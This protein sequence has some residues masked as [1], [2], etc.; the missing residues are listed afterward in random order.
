MGSL[1]SSKDI[2][3]KIYK[4]NVCIING[5]GLSVASG[6]ETFEELS[7]Q[8]WKGIPIYQIVEFPSLLHNPIQVAAFLREKQRIVR[9]A[10]PNPAHKALAEI[11]N[12]NPNV[13]VITHNVDGLEARAG[14]FNLVELYGSLLRNRIVKIKGH[15]INM[16]DII[17][18]GQETSRQNVSL[19]VRAITDS[20]SI[21]VI[22]STL[23]IDEVRVWVDAALKR[24][25]FSVEINPRPQGV[26]EY[27]IAEKAEDCLPEITHLAE[28]F[29]RK[30]ARRKI[31]RVMA[32]IRNERRPQSS[33]GRQETDNITSMGDFPCFF[34][35][36]GSKR[37]IIGL[38]SSGC[39]HAKEN[40]ACTHCGIYASDIWD[41]Q[42]G[43]L[44]EKK[45]A[46]ELKKYDYRKNPVITILQYGSFL[47]SSE[48]QDKTRLKMLRRL[49]R[50]ATL[51]RV[52]IESRPEFITK[53]SI[54]E[55]T[56]ILGDKEI[57]VG[58]A[59]DSKN[60]LIRN[61]ILCKNIKISEYE[62]AIKI[63]KKRDVR[64]LTYILV[65]PPFLSEAEAFREAKE[66]AEYAINQGSYAISLE[67]V[68][69]HSFTLQE[70]LKRYF[71]FR[72]PW[73]WT[74][75]RLVEQL[76]DKRCSNGSPVE[77]RIGGEIHSPP[78]L[79]AAFNCDNCSA[80]LSN[81]FRKHNKAQRRGIF[82]PKSYGKNT[83][84][85]KAL[86]CSCKNSWL[87]I[88]SEE[89]PPLLQH[90][91]NSYNI[92]HTSIETRTQ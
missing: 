37:V 23:R 34:N 63:L 89:S 83:S 79:R 59:L 60:D 3:K 88:L 38:E 13:K 58:L 19:A 71:L 69:A 10:Q 49:S 51:K 73:I 33:R 92:L 80:I 66:T 78:A 68:I 30:D 7:T 21:V 65:K 25:V 48:I 14:V 77:I 31:K 2:A 86:T 39:S 70:T 40:G 57:E 4:G 28:N 76:Q 43:H 15:R 90:I 55:L 81:L 72:E 87:E 84:E 50:Q 52:S 36:K 56:K 20:K 24:D 22:G 47:D 26:T 5:S 82:N 11:V 61:D 35:G 6:L 16:P 67:P 44:V 27:Y 45:F 8:K 74:I 46:K 9:A 18:H 85:F 1:I 29:A 42:K 75:I 12:I 62:R 54:D 53:K 41:P 32:N 91:S 17:L 64:V